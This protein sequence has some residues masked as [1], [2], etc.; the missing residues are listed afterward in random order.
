MMDADQLDELVH[1]LRVAQSEVDRLGTYLSNSGAHTDG[2][3]DVCRCLDF[4]LQDALLKVP[5]EFLADEDDLT[6]Q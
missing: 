1:A 6:L 3:R 2:L 4:A 5:T